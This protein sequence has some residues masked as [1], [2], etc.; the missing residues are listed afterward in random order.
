MSNNAR[1]LIAVG[2]VRP[3]GIELV[4]GPS[5]VCEHCGDAED[6]VIRVHRVHDGKYIQVAEC[7]DSIA[8]WARWDKKFGVTSIEGPE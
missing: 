7:R 3:K 2:R 5:L 1:H 6:V 8:C 4:T